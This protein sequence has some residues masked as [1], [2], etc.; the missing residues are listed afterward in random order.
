M[1]STREAAREVWFALVDRKGLAYNGTRACSVDVPP[2]I[3]ISRFCD[4]VKEK[5]DRQGDDL[6]GILSSKLHVYANK[7]AFD[8][9]VELG[10]RVKI[11]EELGRDNELYVVVPSPAEDHPVKRKKMSSVPRATWFTSELTDFCTVELSLD[12]WLAMTYNGT[13]QN[14]SLNDKEKKDSD[15]PM[16]TGSITRTFQRFVMDFPVLM[17][18]NG[19]SS[20]FVR[21]CYDEL[22]KLLLKDIEE[23]NQS[24]GITGNPGI[25]KSLFYAYCVF[26]LT[27]EPILGR[28]LIANCADKYAVFEAGEFRYV[29]STKELLGFMDNDNVIRLIDGRSNNLFCWTGVS[30]LFTSPGYSDYKPFL[31]STNVQYVMPPWTQKELSIAAEIAE[32]T[33]KVVK[34]RF[35]EFGGIARYVFS[36]QVHG[37]TS[38]AKEAHS[39]VI[40]DVVSRREEHSDSRA[41]SGFYVTFG[42][43]TIAEKVYDKLMNDCKDK[44]T[45]FMVTNAGDTNSSGFRGKLFEIFCHRLWSSSGGHML[46]GKS[47]HSD[48]QSS[49]GTEY[50]I[51]I[52]DQVEVR[53]FSKLSEIQFAKNLPGAEAK[54]L[55]F[56]PKQKNFA[57]IDAIY[58]NGQMCY[59]LQMTISNDHGIAHESLV[60]IHDWTTELGINYEFVFVVPKGQVQDYKVQNFL[61]TTRHLHKKPSKIAQGLLQY[62]VGVEMI[63]KNSTQ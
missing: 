56:R 14:L 1:D 51:A 54:A 46:I 6:K 24:V 47:L 28:I 13:F 36:K 5:C 10:A 58:W 29:A 16:E 44:L 57:C 9:N 61:T 39:K 34:E 52:P 23:R 59:L 43:D 53:S 41:Y 15:P 55:Y 50:S 38:D 4:A 25:G 17:N 37:H 22:F 40:F 49:Q 19:R 62:A 2:T 8:G 27:Q 20:V 45:E 18:I 30:I 48:S 7:E 42:S 35:D 60:K 3:S 12:E 63:Q 32:T 31:K 21:P 26:R 11:G 33:T